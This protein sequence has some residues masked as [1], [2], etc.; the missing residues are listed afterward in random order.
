MNSIK[1][2]FPII[3]VFLV[4]LIATTACKKK[5][6]SPIVICPGENDQE[7]VQTALIDANEGD[8]IEFCEGTFSFSNGLTMN[9]KHGVTL[10]GEG[11]EKTIFSFEDQQSGAEGILISNSSDIVI[12]GLT[13]LDSHGDGL[14]LKDS[15]SIVMYNVGAEWNG[16]P[17]SENGGYGLY[18]V[19]S[20]NILIDSCYVYGA[21]DSGIYV[22]QSDGAIVRNSLAEGN[23]AGIE[24]ENTTNADVYDN[25]VKD[26]AA[27]ILVFDLPGL[28]MSGNKTRIFDNQISKN[29]R[30]NFAP[31]GSIV[32]EVPAGTG[33]LI[34]STSEVEMFDN[35]LE[36]NNVV[37]TAVASYAALVAMEILPP[38][39]DPDYNPYPG[40]VYIH[41]NSFSR[42]DN[43][44]S[45]DQ[46]SEFGNI[47]VQSFGNELIPDI[48]LD[49]I[50]SPDS[51]DTGSICISENS[52]NSFVNL[53]LA[54]D[55]P[56]NLSFDHEVHDCSIDPLPTVTI[57]IPDF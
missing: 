2:S 9:S 47:L 45:E 13:I 19:N 38:I 33:V 52:G 28:L 14:K 43:Y 49:G 55:F 6:N 23:V 56:N 15:D 35:D 53:N 16:E 4:L 17:S 26:N 25:I 27:G 10:K 29:N 7:R 8:V 32:A 41:D 5:D 37:G 39:Q 11:R 22:G 24:I 30:G 21:S 57:S 48:I 1:N 12:Q 51:G 44:P 42:S 46:Q 31:T 34:L 36:E 40:N 50:F 18:P 3:V 20:S 54:F